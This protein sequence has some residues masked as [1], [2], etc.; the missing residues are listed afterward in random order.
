MQCWKKRLPLHQS[1]PK[2][3]RA[4]THEG[5]LW[6]HR[7]NKSW[8]DIFELIHMVTDSNYINISA[9]RLE[10]IACRIWGNKETVACMGQG[11]RWHAGAVQVW[12]GRQPD[13]RTMC[14]V[15]LCSRP[16]QRKRE[17]QHEGMSK[18]QNNIT[19]Q[20]FKAAL[21]GSVDRAENRGFLMVCSGGMATYEATY[22]EQKLS[23]SVYYDT[24]W[25]LPDRIHTEPIEVPVT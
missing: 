3:R 6:A 14:K 10:D 22:E 11:E 2:W 15:L 19:W 12:M 24:P 21:N 25:V 17:A 16:R 13:D 9:D 18:R 5:L 1:D 23:L 4:T 7:Q 20:C 8:R